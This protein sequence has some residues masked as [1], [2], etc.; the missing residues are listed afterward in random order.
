MIKDA[1]CVTET[2][3]IIINQD[4]YHRCIGQFAAPD[5]C[6]DALMTATKFKNSMMEVGLLRRL[7][8]GGMRNLSLSRNE[9]F[10][11]NF[12]IQKEENMALDKTKVV[13][14][15]YPKSLAYDWQWFGRLSGI[16]ETSSSECLGRDMIWLNSIRVRSGT[17]GMIFLTTLVV[18]PIFWDMVIL[19]R[20]SR[21]ASSMVLTFVLDMVLNHCSIEEEYSKGAIG[22]LHQD[23]IREMSRR[24]GCPSLV[25]VPGRRLA[26]RVNIICT[27]TSPKQISIGA[28][29]PCSSRAF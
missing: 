12:Y 18:D 20:R 28:I 8:E 27:F 25:V 10:I 26:I 3:V 11:L 16:I 24:T 21:S 2:P 17:M 19:K 4:Q 5:S 14:Q 6:W 22:F 15:I 7:L 13:Y 9:I 23:F 29:L 1:G